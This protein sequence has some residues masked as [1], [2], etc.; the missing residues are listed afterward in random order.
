[1]QKFNR[2]LQMFPK[3]DLQ[4]RSL[5][6]IDRRNIVLRELVKSKYWNAIKEEIAEL[7]ALHEA[8]LP[9]GNVGALI[10]FLSSSIIERVLSQLVEVI[11]SKAMSAPDNEG[12]KEVE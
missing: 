9:S 7:A 2:R 11:E 12:L 3:P 1:M 5:S 8:P 10:G 4:P 6:D